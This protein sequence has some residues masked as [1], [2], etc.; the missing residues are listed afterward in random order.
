MTLQIKHVLAAGVQLWRRFTG[1]QSP[2]ER[3]PSIWDFTSEHRAWGW[4]LWILGPI[5]RPYSST[6]DLAPD[7]PMRMDASGWTANARMNPGDLIRVGNPGAPGGHAS[8]YRIA[9]IR[10]YD[11]PKDQW[12]ATLERVG[13]A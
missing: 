13:E 5:P 6:V 11:D 3:A 12:I 8:Y 1:K 7:P 9:T 2:P 4:D 10:Y